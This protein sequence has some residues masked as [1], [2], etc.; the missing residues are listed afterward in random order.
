[1]KKLLSVALLLASSIFLVACNSKPSLD[2]EYRDFYQV[3]GYEVQI[4]SVDT[5]EISGDVIKKNEEEFLLDKKNHRINSGNG[6]IKTYT[7]DEKTGVIT[8]DNNT[9]VRV[10]SPY[11]EELVEGGAVVHD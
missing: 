6:Q 2:G 4:S 9:Y 1:M 5:F 3:E 11:Y 10:N 8:L 7:V